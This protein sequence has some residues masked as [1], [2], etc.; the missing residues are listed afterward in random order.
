M[1]NFEAFRFTHLFIDAQMEDIR[2]YIYMPCAN[3]ASADD[4]DHEYDLIILPTA[5]LAQAGMAV[6]RP[7]IFLV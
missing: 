6:I 1:Y 7:I 2:P 4:H 3:L 5:I